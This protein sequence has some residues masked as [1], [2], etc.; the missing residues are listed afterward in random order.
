MKN[1]SLFAIRLFLL[2]CIVPIVM[3][4]IVY[5]DFSTNY[6]VAVFSKKGFEYQYEN[7]VYKYRILGNTMLLETYD[8]IKHYDLPTVAPRSLNLLDIYGEPQFY[9]AYFYMNTFFLCLTSILLLIILGLH[10]KNMDFM[11]VDLP[12]LF[13]C[14]LMAIT[15]YVVVPYDTLSYFFLSLAAMLII[16]DSKKLWSLLVLCVIVILA[17]LTR[18]TAIF[19]LAFYFALNYKTILIRPTNFKL[20]RKQGELLIITACFICTYIALR[21]ILGYEHAIYQS[22]LFSRNMNLS[23]SLL[24]LLFYVS[25]ALTIFTTTAVTKEISVFFVIT[26]PYVLFLILFAELSEIRLWTPIILLLIIMKVRAYQPIAIQDSVHQV[27]R[28]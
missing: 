3:S 5:T 8:F 28:S 20:N 18:E 22:F 13:L 23:S 25:I 7:G 10:R 14:F 15:Q 16:N 9:S 19:I 24:S 26:L 17:T 27:P 6:T 2:G 11:M 4:S 12:V 21:L 1:N